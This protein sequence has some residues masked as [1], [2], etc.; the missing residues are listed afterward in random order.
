MFSFQQSFENKL[1][2][3]HFIFLETNAWNAFLNFKYS[4]FIIQKQYRKTAYLA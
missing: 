1:D 2:E 4:E 3:I